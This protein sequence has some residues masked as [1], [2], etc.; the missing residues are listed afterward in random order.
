MRA[1]DAPVEAAVEASPFGRLPE[2][3]RSRLLHRA[4]VE[5]VP[6]RTLTHRVGEREPHLELVVVGV[7]R[8]Y[9]TGPNG[10]S[11]TVRYCRT[12]ALT[13]VMSLYADD[14]RMPAYVQALTDA[15]L[16]RLVPSAVRVVAR[17]DGQVAEVLLR[18]LADR[19]HRLVHELPGSVF[20]TVRQRVARHLLDLASEAEVSERGAAGRLT[21]EA[22]QSDLAEAAGSVR[23]V[24]VRVL[25]E[26]RAS[27]VVSTHRDHIDIVDP[28]RLSQAQAGT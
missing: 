20:T 5:R 27:G 7:M 26:L 24:V 8:V 10:R 22:S 23:E 11:M 19:T 17:E 2:P 1:R 14:Y 16:L 3:A 25:A 13:G 18:E 4:R 9:V 21:V 12:G 6:A 28:V 15:Q